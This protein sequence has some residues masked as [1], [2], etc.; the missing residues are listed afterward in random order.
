[1]KLFSTY[2]VQLTG[3]YNASRVIAQGRVMPSGG[4]DAAVKRD[5]LPHNAATLVLSLSDVFNTQR[6]DVDTYQ[7]GVF[8]QNSINKPETRVLKISFMYSFGKELNGDR[9]KA[10]L[11]SNG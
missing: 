7:Q 5:F 6:S 3:N 9:H 2:T 8:F 10:A 11:D 4:L 1:M